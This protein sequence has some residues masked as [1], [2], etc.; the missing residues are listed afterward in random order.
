MKQLNSVT[1]VC[2]DCVNYD[3]A[4][5][6]IMKS[7]K[8]IEP[9][10]AVFLT[11]LEIE[12]PFFE[13]IQ[14]PK[15]RS[16]QSYSDFVL[17]KLFQYV[18]TSHVLLI[19]YDGFVLDASVWNDKFL[20]VDYIGA[21]WMYKDDYNVG[22]GGM[23]MRSRRLMEFVATDPNINITHPEDEC[24]SRLYGQYLRDN[25]FVFASE[26]LANKFSY[27]MN[28]PDQKTFGFHQYYH[29]S[30]KSPI[31]V[32][33]TAAMGDVIMM[34]PLLEYLSNKG[35]QIYLDTNPDWISLFEHLPYKV[36]H[37]SQL[38]SK[39]AVGII[40]MDMAYEKTPKQLILKSYY[41]S[42]G[43][44]DGEIRN[45]NLNFYTPNEARLFRKYAVVHINHTDM[46]Y[47]NIH[48]IDWYTIDMRLKEMGYEVIQ[49]GDDRQK[50]GTWMN[51]QSIKTLMYLIGG[52]SLF[53]GSDSGPAH[54]AIGC[55]IPSVLFF[56]SVNPDYRIANY[57]SIEIIQG[58]CPNAGCYHS[59]VGVSGSGCVMGDLIPRC[60]I[61]NTWNV[62]G[63]IRKI[64]NSNIRVDS[65]SMKMT[66]P[67]IN[68][69]YELY[70]DVMLSICGDQRGSMI[71][72]GCNLAPCTPLLGF[73][74]RK[75]IDIVPRTLDHPGE[76]Q[77]FEQG[78]ILITDIHYYYDTS[79]CSDVIE[80]LTVENGRKILARMEDR[81]DR[82]ILFTPLD[83]TFGFDYE[84]D[85]PEH[86]RSL[87]KPEDFNGYASIVFPHY[88]PQLNAG[89]FFFW[90]CK[91]IESD[92]DRVLFQIQDK[93]DKWQKH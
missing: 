24:L 54:I 21:R 55:K 34:E 62:L 60:S 73:K 85:D 14:I 91:N 41:E 58:E 66:I 67:K 50:C 10:R 37:V 31:I 72:L 6:A 27:E 5:N 7:L 30:F 35:Y 93:I 32:K 22:N 28:P 2:I 65:R 92:F 47:R 69:S 17:R 52:A 78:D 63:A 49:I 12:S 44:N 13:T 29:D 4:I 89:A 8:E 59:V 48:G 39:D 15:I 9:N 76:Q 57:D 84:T 42:I 61:H 1:L 33:R 68:G 36:K 80:H 53:I 3:G 70:M 56:G 43:I 11:D 51:T 86:H 83:D 19:Q 20:E 79:I 45:A 46:P 25:G 87:W 40:N 38:V 64:S 26:E 77:Y 74:K 23:S 16:K 71:D 88:H 90:K 82:Q 18:D 81:S 75:Y